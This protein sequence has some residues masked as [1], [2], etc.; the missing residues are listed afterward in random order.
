MLK[1]V[2]YVILAI[3]FLIGTHLIAHEHNVNLGPSARPTVSVDANENEATAT[4]SLDPLR[5]ME[6][7]VG[8]TISFTGKGYAYAKVWYYFSDNESGSIPETP[9]DMGTIAVTLVG[10]S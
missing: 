4:A 1:K 2:L 8:E 7:P 9:E 5:E 3:A 6:L 10:N